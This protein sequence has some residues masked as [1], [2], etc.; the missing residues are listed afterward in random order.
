MML[1]A[2]LPAKMCAVPHL[3][4]FSITDGKARV[5]SHHRVRFNRFP[6][7]ALGVFAKM[8]LGIV[9]MAGHR[10]PW[11]CLDRIAGLSYPYVLGRLRIDRP[12]QV[13]CPDITYIP[14]RKGNLHA[15]ETGPQAKAG[16]GR[17]ITLYDHQRPHA[18]HGG[19][20]PAVGQ[21]NSTETDQQVKAAI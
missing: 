11:S 15:W 20:A 3:G 1:I 9:M 4:H 6:T 7:S 19:H 17:G 10:L 16:V 12:N 13:W 21:V 5:K 8:G 2:T 14:L 18:A